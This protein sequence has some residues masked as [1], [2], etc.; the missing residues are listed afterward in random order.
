MFVSSSLAQP[1]VALFF[2]LP[3]NNLLHTLAHRQWQHTAQIVQQTACEGVK[4]RGTHSPVREL[5]A[6]H[7]SGARTRDDCHSHHSW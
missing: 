3:F 6:K 7:N 1:I 2:A 5:P 4:S